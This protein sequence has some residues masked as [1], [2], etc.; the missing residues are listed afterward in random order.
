MI[1]SAAARQGERKMGNETVEV[2]VAVAVV[3]HQGALLIGPRPAGSALEGLWEFPGG[4]VRPAESPA[5][6]AVRECRE[7]TGLAVE[8]VGTFPQR[9]Q[10]YSHG[11][12]WLRFF[13]CRPIDWEYLPRAPFRWIWRS[14]LG[15]FRFPAGNRHVL[16]RLG[17][18][19]VRS[20]MDAVTISFTLGPC[21]R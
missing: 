11:R 15:S 12:V 9:R 6:A 14:E 17:L 13:H 4:K 16:Q 10:R 19:T 1:R 8:V 3:E 7:E 18:Q 21:G 20:S 5:E 2:P